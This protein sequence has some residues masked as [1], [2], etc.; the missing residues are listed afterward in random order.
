[1][2]YVETPDGVPWYYEDHESGSTILLIH[3]GTMNAEY[4]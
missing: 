1:M 3:G 2:P 4:W